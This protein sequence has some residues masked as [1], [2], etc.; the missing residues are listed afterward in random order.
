MAGNK[1]LKAAVRAKEDEFYTQLTDIEKEMRYYS[2]SKIF[3]WYIGAVTTILCAYAIYHDMGEV[4]MAI[5]PSGF[6]FA[7]A[8]YSTKIYNL[9]KEKEQ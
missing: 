5:F 9:R 2:R 8:L 1:S 6:G 3:A 7:V 4:V